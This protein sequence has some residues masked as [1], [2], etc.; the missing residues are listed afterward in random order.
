[1][2]SLPFQQRQLLISNTSL[3]AFQMFFSLNGPI[4][5]LLWTSLIAQL[6]KNLPAMQETW[7]WFLGWKDPLEKEVETHSSILAWRIP[8]TEEPGGLQSMG[9]QKVG[10]DWV[11]K[12]PPQR[13]SAGS[14]ASIQITILAW[15]RAH[16]SSRGCDSV[17]V[18]G[19][20]FQVTS[21]ATAMFSLWGLERWFLYI[22]YLYTSTWKTSDMLFVDTNEK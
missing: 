22:S 17:T 20:I 5:F 1:M 12:P 13:L 11:T 14:V 16:V 9:S 3:S 8:C 19:H 2:A 18:G 21:S 15:S 7:V 6:V 4:D 10:H